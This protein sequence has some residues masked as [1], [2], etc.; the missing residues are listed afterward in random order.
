MTQT[1]K[2][3]LL[4]KEE[5]QFFLTVYKLV[6]GY[7][8]VITD[9]LHTLW[10]K[11]FLCLEAAN[12]KSLAI[13]ESLILMDKY[14]FL[15]EKYYKESRYYDSIGNEK[16]TQAYLKKAFFYRDKYNNSRGLQIISNN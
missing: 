14:L 11:D 8:G 3:I 15:S 6:D 10:R 12:K 16:E 7:C 2:N 13:F 5:S 4:Y 1:N 9:G